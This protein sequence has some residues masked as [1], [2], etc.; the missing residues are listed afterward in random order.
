MSTNTLDQIKQTEEQ[1]QKNIDQANK[2]IEKLIIEA[3]I[4]GKNSLADCENQLPSQI[5]DIIDQAK[6]E[7]QIL[8]ATIEHDKTDQLQKLDGVESKTLDQA[9]SAVIKNITK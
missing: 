4:K 3:G 6:K 8:K 5:E 2:D 9:A 7:I 1:A